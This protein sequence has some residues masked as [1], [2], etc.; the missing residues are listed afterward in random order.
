MLLVLVEGVDDVAG[1]G[2]GRSAGLH[3][4][5]SMGDENGGSPTN[6]LDEEKG[7]DGDGAFL[8]G[9]RSF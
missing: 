1:P 6:E 8:G 2:V 4:E 5:L 9:P 3:A 7:D